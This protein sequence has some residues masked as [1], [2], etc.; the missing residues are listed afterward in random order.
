MKSYKD[1]EIYKLAYKLA[2][3]VHDMTMKLPKYETYEQGSQ[4]RRASKR[5]KDTI[6]EGYGRRR[7]K[8][9]FIRF[10]IFAHASCDETMSQLE[11]IS[12]IH[13]SD[14]PLTDLIEEYDKLGRKINRFIRY[15]EQNWQ[16]T[17]A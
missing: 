8:D 14:N 1:L 15:V 6:A 10:L 12:D 17:N 7:Y 5:I 4:V 2:I 9:E 11:M 3:E 16:T 13:F